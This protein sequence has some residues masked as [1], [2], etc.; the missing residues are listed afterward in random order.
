MQEGTSTAGQDLFD[1]YK[2]WAAD[3]G[4][5]AFGRSGFYEAIERGGAVVGVRLTRHEHQVFVEGAR[6]EERL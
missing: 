6:L 1:A 2:R 4:V 3:A 5:K